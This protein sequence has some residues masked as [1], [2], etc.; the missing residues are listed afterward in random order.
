MNSTTQDIPVIIT[1]GSN[2]HD[3]ER[4]VK[5][6]CDYLRGIINDIHFSD[7]V[8]APSYTGIGADYVNIAVTGTCSC[9]GEAL[10]RELRRYEDAHGR[11]RPDAQAIVAIDIDIVTYGED[12]L[13]PADMAQPWLGRA[14]ALIRDC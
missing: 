13:K 10:H 5:E 3:A 12:I 8:C 6:A 2:A 11:R 9:S 1:I 14:L 7:A 4:R